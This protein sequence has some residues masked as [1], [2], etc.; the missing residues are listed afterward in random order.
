V[1]IGDILAEA[2]RQAGLTMTQVSQQTRIREALIR[3]IEH[4]DFSACGG[5]FYA[6]GHIRSVAA[7]VGIDPAPLIRE[8]D[9]EHG[10]LGTIGA[11]QIFEP[12][13]PIRIR[14]PRPLPLR[15]VAAVVLLGAAGYG[16]Y[17]A[18]SAPGSQP[19]ATPAARVRPAAP[20]ATVNLAPPKPAAPAAPKNEAVIKL[21]A[22]SAC[23]VGL[24]DASGKSIFQGTVQAGKTMTWE[25]KKPVSLVLGNPAGVQLTVNGKAEQMN[26]VQVVTLTINPS[27]KTPVT[28]G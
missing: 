12:V 10:P 3:S 1:S 26:T 19:S 28:G 15:R 22:T 5:N 8:F 14:E 13:T 18:F 6:R 25:E 4:D 21:A 24:N 2:R 27:S 20:S 11:A 7:A 16:A 9:A 17:Y 23:W